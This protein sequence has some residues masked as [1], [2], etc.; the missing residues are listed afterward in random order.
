[1]AAVKPGDGVLGRWRSRAKAHLRPLLQFAVSAGVTRACARH[2]V[3]A[4]GK[5]RPRAAQELLQLVLEIASPEEVH[6]IYSWVRETEERDPRSLEYAVQNL[7]RARG[8]IE[9]HG[10]GL[11]DAR[12]L[13]LG[14]GYSLALGLLLHAFGARSYVAVDLFPIAVDDARFYRD[15]RRRLESGRGL[16]L[17]PARDRVLA[18]FDAATDLRG[19]RAE[20]GGA[21]RLLHPVDAAR[22]PFADGSLDVVY[23]NAALEHVADPEAVL[24]ES[25]RVLAPDGLALHQ[26][27]FRD[28]RPGHGPWDFLTVG[29]EAWERRWAG[30]FNYTNRRRAGWFLRA[31][32]ASGF[33]EVRIE[34][35]ERGVPP[36]GLRARL[37]P[38]FKSLSDDDLHVTSALFIA[39]RR[40]GPS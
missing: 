38:G 24:R 19:E 5:D 37:A 28:H 13:E 25:A 1:M 14:P 4:L 40:P 33:A 6:A 32:A 7:G 29:D 39:R 22:L 36:A 15:L 21:V 12:I 26:V 11:E 17:G 30:D 2:A 8:L 10:R 16:P 3:G 31:L 20:L 23:S 9:R 34:E 18:R 35:A 27:D